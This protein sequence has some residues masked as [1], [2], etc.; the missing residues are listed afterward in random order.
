MTDHEPD[1]A[2]DA[3]DILRNCGADVLRSAVDAAKIY[4]GPDHDNA[5]GTTGKGRPDGPSV[6]PL[7]W[8]GEADLQADRPW[9]VKHL[10]PEVGTALLSGQWGTAKTFVALDLATAVMTGRSFAGRRVMRRGG[11]LF[12]PAEGAFEIPIRLKGSTL[13]ARARPMASA[14]RSL[15]RNGVHACWITAHFQR[16][17]QSRQRQAGG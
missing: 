2:P 16:W 6:I 5:R 17:K 1:K 7:R 12:L 14:C 10:L 4:T 15:G 13:M 3:D 8:H 9:L 11:V